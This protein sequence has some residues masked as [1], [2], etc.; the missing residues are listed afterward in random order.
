MIL[1]IGMDIVGFGNIFG[2]FLDLGFVLDRISDD[3]GSTLGI[4]GLLAQD[5]IP[6][7]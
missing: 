5:R 7:I 3:S 6:K 4:V 1:M 2:V